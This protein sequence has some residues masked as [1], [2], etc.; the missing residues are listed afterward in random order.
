M[1]KVLYAGS[2]RVSRKLLARLYEMQ[3]DN[4]FE[5]VGVLTNP[6]ASRGRHKTLQETDVAEFAN[7]KKIRTFA[8]EHLN[9]NARAE[10]EK[11]HADVLVC[12]AYGHIF[13]PKFLALFK[14]GGVNVHPSLLPKYRGPTP[15]NAA[16]L[17]M[18]GETAI[19]IQRLSLGM[20]EGDILAQE[21][22]LLNGSETATLLLEKTAER[23]SEM[24]AK[25]LYACDLE[26]KLPSGKAQTGNASYTKIISKADCKIDWNESA[27][28]IDARI[29]AFSDE[30]GA[31][32][33]DAHGVLKILKA[34]ILNENDFVS[35]NR[36]AKKIDEREMSAHEIANEKKVGE[37]L[38]FQK[39][40][41]IL[42]QTGN[43]VL[44]IRELQREGKKAMDAASFV[45]GAR[46]FVGSVL[47]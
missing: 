14:F 19:T 41:G 7:E 27:K 40:R 43:G 38:C 42:V 18:D 11:L 26:K 10:I 45:N 24:L 35:G 8:F 15:V 47:G 25:I 9:A 1:V 23:G 22:I 28:K 17:N 30:P 39:K 36:S 4:H 32:T 6:P 2:P 12:F 13:G 21:K 20:D 5:I 33:S 3:N 16:I 37:V 44:C 29:R 31:W 46:D 34:R